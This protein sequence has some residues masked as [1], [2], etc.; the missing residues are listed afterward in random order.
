V[1]NTEHEASKEHGGNEQSIAT[2]AEPWAE[3]L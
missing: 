2:D 3:E 1:E